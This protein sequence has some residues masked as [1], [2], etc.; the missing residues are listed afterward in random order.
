[1]TKCRKCGRTLEEV[2]QQDGIFCMHCDR[3]FICERCKEIE[4]QETINSTFKKI[5]NGTLQKKVDHLE[6][7]LEQQKSN[8]AKLKQYLEKAEEF[9]R[10]EHKEDLVV[11]SICA[12]NILKI[13]EKLEKGNEDEKNS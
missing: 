12:S 3:P 5:Y 11:L 9:G 2:M 13:M 4:E 8:W 1:M 10:S 6:K 7:Q